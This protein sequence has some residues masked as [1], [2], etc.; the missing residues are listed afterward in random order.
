MQ[1][2]LAE[3]ARDTHRCIF[4]TQNSTLSTQMTSQQEMICS[5]YT[6]ALP[7]TLVPTS[8]LHFLKNQPQKTKTKKPN[9]LAQ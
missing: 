5:R 3:L 9:K 8:A 7:I 1:S 2:S 4:S 6:W